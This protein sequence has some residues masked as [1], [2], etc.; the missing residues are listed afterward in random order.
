MKITMSILIGMIICLHL[1]IEDVYAKDYIFMIDNSG[2]MRSSKYDANRQIPDSISQFIELLDKEYPEKNE[3]IAIIKFQ[4]EAT[5]LLPLTNVGILVKN[6]KLLQNAFRAL[7]YRG[8][9]TIFKPA[10]ETFV[11]TMD[12]RASETN[13]ILISDGKPDIVKDTNKNYM[14]VEDDSYESAT[15]IRNSIKPNKN[16]H[17]HLFPFSTNSKTD[18]L[19]RFAYAMGQPDAVKKTLSTGQELFQRLKSRFVFICNSFPPGNV[20]FNMKILVDDAD[21]IFRNVFNIVKY[22]LQRVYQ[23]VNLRNVKM[24]RS[25]DYNL[26]T[27]ESI[28]TKEEQFELMRKNKV[29]GLCMI[30]ASDEQSFKYKIIGCKLPPIK[31]YCKTR[32]QVGIDQVLANQF[33]DRYQRQEEKMIEQVVPTDWASLTFKINQ[34]G[35]KLPA[36]D[37]LRCRVVVMDPKNPGKV[38]SEY[39]NSTEKPTN[40]TGVVTYHDIPRGAPLTFELLPMAV[41]FNEILAKKFIKRGWKKDLTQYDVVIADTVE[42]YP[43]NIIILAYAKPNEFS[44]SIARIGVGNVLARVEYRANK[45]GEWQHLIDIKDNQ[46]ELDKGKLLIGYTYEIKA[47]LKGFFQ[48]QEIPPPPLSNVPV[49]A[50][51]PDRKREERFFRKDDSPDVHLEPNTIDKKSS[52]QPRNEFS[53]QYDED[54]YF[55][56]TKILYI[57]GSTTIIKIP[58]FLNLPQVIRKNIQQKRYVGRENELFDLIIKFFKEPLVLGDQTCAFKLA[59]DLD[60][61]LMLAEISESNEIN[62]PPKKKVQLWGDLLRTTFNCKESKEIHKN[63][64]TLATAMIVRKLIEQNSDLQK[65]N[66]KASAEEAILDIQSRYKDQF[67]KWKKAAERQIKRHI[68]F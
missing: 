6:K 46:P 40:S 22:K 25:I 13:L 53:A 67:N 26:T 56:E 3:R 60:I 54:A 47:Q 23:D 19:K 51:K 64:L 12:P 32:V 8:H 43:D 21:D 18:Y 44:R 10:F 31:G 5:I 35:D 29:H 50:E 14:Y 11:R 39:N 15:I 49:D 30:Y 20:N 57:T 27:W 65:S 68:T 34:Q 55:K 24:E 45:D 28:S 58:F 7:N 16:V 61:F 62:F 33:I 37:K 17:F 9:W 2:S 38:Y 36:I 42:N 48:T 1:I 52:Q 59:T 66:Y 4:E 41:D 63:T